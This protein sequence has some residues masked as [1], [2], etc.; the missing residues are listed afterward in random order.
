[1]TFKR[2]PPFTTDDVEIV[3]KSTV[4]KGFFQLDQYRLRHRLFEGGWSGEM[5]SEI[6]ERGH[7]VAIL[8]YDPEHDKVVLIE[9][10]RPGAY[11][12]LA[13]EWF[14]NKTS[15]WLLECVAGIIEKGEKPV[16]VAKREMIEE[17]GL[18]VSH[19]IKIFHYL[20]SPG[21]SSESVFLYCGKVDATNANGIFGMKNEHENIRVFSTSTEEA[22]ELLDRGMITNAMT[23]I[24]LQ[25]LKANYDRVRSEWRT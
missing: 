4:F 25:W 5:I 24:G 11:A 3:K 8:P 18:K 1:M 7:A 17:T 16:D 23:I 12:A 20:V 13:Y 22:F 6:F 15:P 9:Q 10:F 2:Q 14:D 21:G 19:L